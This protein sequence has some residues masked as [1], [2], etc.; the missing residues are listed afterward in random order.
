MFFKN[1]VDARGLYPITLLGMF[2]AEQVFTE[3]SQRFTITSLRDGTHHPNSLHY[4]G[5]AFDI[6]IFDLR[7]VSAHKMALK[8]KDRLPSGFQI[9]LESDH[10]HVEFDDG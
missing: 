2:V 1:G 8:L 3:C 4:K 7:N 9:A 10:I 6:R 5:L